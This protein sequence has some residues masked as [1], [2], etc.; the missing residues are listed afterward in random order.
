M[1]GRQWQSAGLGEAPVGELGGTIAI[2][3][4]AARAY[5]VGARSQKHHEVSAAVLAAAFAVDALVNVAA[6]LGYSVQA[7]LKKRGL[8]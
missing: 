7:K 3:C 4:I 6:Y 1:I 2:V 8:T 5:S